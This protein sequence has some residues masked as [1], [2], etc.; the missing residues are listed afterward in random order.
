MNP[1]RNSDAAR[2]AESDRTADQ[3]AENARRRGAP[4][5]ALEEHDETGERQREQHVG[6]EARVQRSNDGA[7]VRDSA[8]ESHTRDNEPGHA[9]TPRR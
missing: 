6:E 1:W 3:R 2:D 8:H 7:R 9:A 5:R 4:K